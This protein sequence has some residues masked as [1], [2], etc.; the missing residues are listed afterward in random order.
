MTEYS[1]DQFSPME[2]GIFETNTIEVAQDQIVNCQ[3]N[4]EF[5][6]IDQ[7]ENTFESILDANESNQPSVDLVQKGKTEIHLET[8]EVC[9]EQESGFLFV[10]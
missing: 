2:N 5:D 7:N 1:V 10:L 6:E 4:A 8:E 9:I 3:T